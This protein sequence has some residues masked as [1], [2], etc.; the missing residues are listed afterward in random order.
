MEAIEGGLNLDV[1]M[2]T[3]S[4]SMVGAGPSRDRKS[5][6]GTNNSMCWRPHDILNIESSTLEEFSA[7]LVSSYSTWLLGC[8]D[9]IAIDDLLLVSCFVS[10]VRTLIQNL[11]D[12][13]HITLTE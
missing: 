1:Q 3:T 2:P 6:S 4:D 13:E 8:H 11:L 5:S 9:K 7:D 10:G 12:L